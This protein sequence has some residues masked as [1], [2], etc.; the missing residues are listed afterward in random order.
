MKKQNKLKSTSI[1]RIKK[2]FRELLNSSET[3]KKDYKN[4]SDIIKNRVEELKTKF[5]GKN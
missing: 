3:T 2:F 5:N 1:N 4:S